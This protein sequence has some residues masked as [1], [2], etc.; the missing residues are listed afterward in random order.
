MSHHPRLNS[1]LIRANTYETNTSC[2]SYGITCSLVSSRVHPGHAAVQIFAYTRNSSCVF[3]SS[4]VWFQA[5]HSLAWCMSTVF[6]IRFFPCASVRTCKA[7]SVRGQ[8]EIPRSHRVD[9]AQ[10]PP[11]PPASDGARPHRLLEHVRVGG[12]RL[13]QQVKLRLGKRAR[14]VCKCKSQQT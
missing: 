1:L 6:V 12:H 9:A 7:K 14:T 5:T 3:Q 2:V 11:L 13:L 4:L 8:Q 10:L